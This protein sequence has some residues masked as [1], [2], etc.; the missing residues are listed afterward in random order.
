MRPSPDT[1]LPAPATAFPWTRTKTDD[2]RPNRDQALHLLLPR[3]L[4]HSPLQDAIDG[5]QGLEAEFPSL[6]EHTISIKTHGSDVYLV[7]RRLICV[8]TGKNGKRMSRLAFPRSGRIVAEV[9]GGLPKASRG[10]I[11]TG[12]RNLQYQSSVQ[13]AVFT[14][15]FPEEQPD[16]RYQALR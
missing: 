1:A 10:I 8:R 14:T 16:S 12:Q 6:D 4:R 15:E 11:S 2:W 3:S 13:L 7:L 9:R 5:E